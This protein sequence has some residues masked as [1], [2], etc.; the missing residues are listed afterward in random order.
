M[1]PSKKSG[2]AMG[3]SYILKGLKKSNHFMERQVERRVSDAEVISILEKG[4]RIVQSDGK[5]RYSFGVSQLVVDHASKTL[6][7]IHPGDRPAKGMK[8][9]GPEQERM[10]R[11]A[12]RSA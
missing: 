1:T 10:M 8:L 7:T 2:G 6:V 9:F 4:T 3:I 11:A 12:I 5:I